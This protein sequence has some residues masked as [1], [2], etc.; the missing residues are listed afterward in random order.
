[1]SEGDDVSKVAVATA[2][3]HAPGGGRV[4]FD[5]GAEFVGDVVDNRVCAIWHA[6]DPRQLDGNERLHR[7]G[8]PGHD[9]VGDEVNVE[10][11]ERGGAEIRDDGNTTCARPLRFDDA[12]WT[13][14]EVEPVGDVKGCA[15]AKGSLGLGEIAGTTVKVDVPRVPTHASE[16]RQHCRRSLEQPEVW[17]VREDAIEETVV[18]EL[19]LQV[20]EQQS[21]PLASK[22]TQ[23]VR[24][25][26]SQC[27]RVRVP[28]LAHAPPASA[29]LSDFSLYP[30]RVSR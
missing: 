26:L 30:A 1:M 27:L 18:G 16:S 22:A 10:G 23:T 2:S 24:Q 9:Q 21:G 14:G 19:S 28:R 4:S 13:D 17:I 8:Y 20:L 5:E 6:C 29:S 7:V 15:F 12:A 3:L 25:C 11:R